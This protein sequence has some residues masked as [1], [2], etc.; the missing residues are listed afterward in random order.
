MPPALPSSPRRLQQW[1]L[2]LALLAAC[3]TT[4]PAN[5]R[6]RRHRATHAAARRRAQSGP[7][8]VVVVGER[9]SILHHPDNGR[10]VERRPK[11][12]AATLTGVAFSDDQHGWAVG[13]E[14]V[15]LATRDGGLTWRRELQDE[16]VRT[17]FL[18]VLALD[19]GPWSSPS[20]PSGQSWYHRRRRHLT[21]TSPS[22]A[23]QRVSFEPHHPRSH[24]HP[25]PGRRAGTLLRF[26]RPGV[27]W[28]AIH[29]PYDGSVSYGI[30]PSSLGSGVLLVPTVCA[31]T[32]TASL[33]PTAPGSRSPMSTR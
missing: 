1:F 22:I 17:S 11:P 15:M 3:A 29:S 19:E 23:R 12:R 14:G 18:D 28:T 27:S 25:L 8:R 16:S 21:W 4:A 20:A 32:S 9:G 5:E 6:G 31:A 13:H 24:G 10:N 33:W 26:D 2:W 30:L 7:N